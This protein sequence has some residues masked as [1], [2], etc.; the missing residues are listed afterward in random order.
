MTQY[1]K[2][3]PHEALDAKIAGKE[4]EIKVE[5][6]TGWEISDDWFIYIKDKYRIAV[7]SYVPEAEEIVID[8]DNNKR[9]FFAMDGNKYALRSAVC[10]DTFYATSE[11]TPVESEKKVAREGWMIPACLE[12]APH[13]DAIYVREVLEDDN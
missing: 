9:R 11:V 13:M 8:G 6:A 12:T 3:T 10:P 1:K 2:L 7:E 5:L 4:I